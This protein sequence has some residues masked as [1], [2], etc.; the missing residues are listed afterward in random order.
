MVGSKDF[1]HT[2]YQIYLIIIPKCLN[3]TIT[4]ESQE[5]IHHCSCKNMATSV[6]QWEAHLAFVGHLLI[7]LV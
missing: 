2:G 7:G 6:Y 1:V 4:R 3:K 5:D